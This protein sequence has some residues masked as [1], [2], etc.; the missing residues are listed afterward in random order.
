MEAWDA[1]PGNGPLMHQQGVVV[2]YNSDNSQL[3]TRLNWEAAKALEFGVPEEEALNFVT[4]NPAK[5]LKIDTKV[6][7][8]E[9][10]KDADIAIWNGS[11][12]STITKCEQTWVDGRKYF[13]LKEDEEMRK[14]I[15]RQRAVLVQKIL[16]SKKETA[17]TGASGRMPRRSN[18]TE[19]QSCIDEVIYEN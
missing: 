6:G 4:L 15:E 11:P 17:D 16:G 19:L 13:D 18:E 1:I 7:S 14:D 10:G 2:S 5:Q 8:I 12:L 3:A 9:A